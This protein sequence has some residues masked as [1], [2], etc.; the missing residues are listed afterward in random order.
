MAVAVE[1]IGLTDPRAECVEQT[2]VFAR[3]WLPTELVELT[4]V[5]VKVS[6][7]AGPLF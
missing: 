3:F 5:A 4:I 7:E 2:P 6:T 1:S